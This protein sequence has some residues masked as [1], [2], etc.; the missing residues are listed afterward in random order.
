MLLCLILMDSLD[1]DFL[2][3]F[4]FLWFG[5]SVGQVGIEAV[6]GGR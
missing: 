5:D 2:F 4:C 1:F 3:S 6:G